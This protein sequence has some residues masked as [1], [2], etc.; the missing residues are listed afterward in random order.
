M[1][2]RSSMA[3]LIARVRL[4]INDTL[5]QG[6]GQIWS[7]Q[8]IQDVMDESREDLMNVVLTPK[9]TFTGS[10]IQ[11]LDYYYELGGW[12]DDYVIKQYLVNPV[13]P[14]TSEPIAAHWQFAQTTL[15]PLYISGKLYDVYR[16]A[17][18]LLER[19]AAQWALSY[20]ISVDGQNLQRSQAA[21]AL[22]NLAK[23]YRM[24]QRARTI[25]LIRTDQNRMGTLAAA[26]GAQEI[27]YMGSGDG[28]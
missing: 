19:Q 14:A 3:A 10:T 28:R 2:V 27:D 15:P 18:D 1:A 8:T 4:L 17:A 12:E 6:S 21:V 22:Q 25:S 20:N 16:S 11:F 13:T 7:D 23:T 26:L 9:P 24:K 5:P